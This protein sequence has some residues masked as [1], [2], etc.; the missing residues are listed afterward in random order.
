ML[1][2]VGG[3][4]HKARVE[5][6]SWKARNALWGPKYR[7]LN[8]APLK[9]R[10]SSLSAHVCWVCKKGGTSTSGSAPASDLAWS[11]GERSWMVL[12]SYET[13]FTRRLLS[14]ATS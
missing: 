14:W 7:V 6:T 1:A 3:L 2:A 9:K 12:P 11:G 5:H 10:S 8:S 4:G 13:C